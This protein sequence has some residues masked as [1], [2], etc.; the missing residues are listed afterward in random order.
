MNILFINC[1][2]RLFDGLDC[3]AANRSTLF[4]KALSKVGHVDVVSFG[5]ESPVSNVANCDVVYCKSISHRADSSRKRMMRLLRLLVSPW[6]VRGFYT[7]DCQCEEVVDTLLRAKRYDLIACRYID[8]AARC[9]LQR[10]ADR[11]VLDVDDNLVSASL[12][13]LSNARPSNLLIRWMFLYR[14]HAIGWMQKNFL[15]K[16]RISFYSNI[17]EP[18]S[19]R[20][21]FLH[22]ATTLERPIADITEQTPLR[23]LIV[24]WLDF[25]PNRIG[26]LHFVEN[27]FP[28]IKKAVPEAELHIVGK[29]C[30][31]RL[32]D[33][34]NANNGVKA[35]GFVE[36]IASEYEQCRVIIVPVYQGA[37]TS[38]KFAEGL[39]MNRPIVA[40]PMGARGFEHLC[41]V[42]SEYLSADDDDM[43][44][45]HAAQ[46]LTSTDRALRIARNANR[47]GRQH[48]SKECFEKTVVDSVNKA[49]M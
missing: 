24:G 21:I 37:G 23:L 41:R 6:D 34:L 39:M 44:A 42:G 43:F 7:L 5:S 16:V 35:L 30:N 22:N 45:Q 47:V 25:A 36:D 3:G 13:D 31:A 20:S 14:A 4:V 28:T 32:K 49:L 17:L 33:R 18:P 8:E 26:T 46:L 1:K 19:C 38:V 12:R 48:F 15:R 11:L 2:Y 9:G 40:T 29:T 10:Y 27:V